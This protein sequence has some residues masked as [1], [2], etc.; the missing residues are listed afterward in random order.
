MLLTILYILTAVMVLM[1]VLRLGYSWGRTT[2]ED[3]MKEYVVSK[4]WL[5]GIE[6]V[7]IM[8]PEKNL[9]RKKVVIK[10]KQEGSEEIMQ[11]TGPRLN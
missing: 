6:L 7:E 3:I 4:P 5:D 1:V 11:L 2:S 10:L 8:F 9:S